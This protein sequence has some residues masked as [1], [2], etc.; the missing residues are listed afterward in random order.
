MYNIN[1][2]KDGVGGSNLKDDIP[3]LVDLIELL[4]SKKTNLRD[5]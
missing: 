5:S 4:E 1:K 3:T 2:L